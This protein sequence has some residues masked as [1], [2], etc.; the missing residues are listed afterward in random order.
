MLPCVDEKRQIRS[1]PALLTVQTRAVVY[2]ENTFFFPNAVCAA[3]YVI[4][5]LDK[6]MKDK[7][8]WN[9]K[10]GCLL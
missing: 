8:V 7:H 2:V 6:Q 1:Q 9:N 4:G 3:L 5:L 10:S